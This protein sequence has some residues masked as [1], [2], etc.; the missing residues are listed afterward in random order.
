MRESA[1]ELRELYPDESR[2]A[3]ERERF[4]AA[5][6]EHFADHPVSPPP[7]ARTCVMD[8]PQWTAVQRY[9]PGPIHRYV[10]PEPTP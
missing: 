2:L 4:I 10:S 6:R 5:V 7:S 9:R 1:R 3:V 8:C